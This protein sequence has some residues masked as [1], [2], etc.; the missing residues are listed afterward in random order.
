MDRTREE[1]LVREALPSAVLAAYKAAA[2][3]G[4]CPLEAESEAN[5]AT[6]EAVRSWRAGRGVTLSRWV[7]D[8]VWHRVADLARGL[9][10]RRGSWK[11][12]RLAKPTLSLSMAGGPNSLC[13]RLSGRE[14]APGERLEREEA[15]LA[16]L[17]RLSP[18][19]RL[20]V[21]ATRVEGR[22]LDDVAEALGVSRSRVSQ[23]RGEAEAWL[24]ETEAQGKGA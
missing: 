21:W 24:R 8:H 5:L 2:A 3:R 15:G 10:G 19:E 11:A 16:V 13:D 18:R 9:H 12:R 23:L 20:A 22:T 17:R 1:S 4:V 6:L 14:P 7:N